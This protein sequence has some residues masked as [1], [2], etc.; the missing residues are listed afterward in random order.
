MST[1]TRQSHRIEDEQA[2]DLY[3]EDRFGLEDDVTDED[4]ADFLRQQEEPETKPGFFNLPTIAGLATIGVGAAYLL[5]RYGLFATQFNIGSLVGPW[6][7]GVL[8]ILL[9]FVFLSWKPKRQRRAAARRQAAERRARQRRERPAAGAARAERPREESTAARTAPG[10]KQ[11]ARSRTNRKIAGVAG[12]IGEYFGID[13]T[14]VRIAL[15]VALIASGAM[16]IPL[17]VLL[18]IVM[19]NA[20]TPRAQPS[21][22]EPLD[23]DRVVII[24]S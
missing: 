17:Y 24:R 10:R 7:I 11:F 6:I 22:R 15:V 1:R 19:P 18:A 12:G 4:I 3:R 8:I 5:E 21:D 13:P 2:G 14:I 9:G 20:D 23:D 16:V